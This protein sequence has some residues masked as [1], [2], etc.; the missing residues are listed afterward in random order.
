MLLGKVENPTGEA[1]WLGRKMH[2]V[3]TMVSV[4]YL[5]RQEAFQLEL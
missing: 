3:V 2:S 1:D 5:G 4:R